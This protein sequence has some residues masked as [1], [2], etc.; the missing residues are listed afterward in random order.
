MDECGCPGPTGLA[1]CAQPVVIGRGIPSDHLLFRTS[2]LWNESSAS[3]AFPYIV[4]AAAS[5]IPSLRDGIL[6][7]ISSTRR[8]LALPADRQARGIF[9]WPPSPTTGPP[10]LFFGGDRVAAIRRGLFGIFSDTRQTSFALQSSGEFTA[11]TDIERFLFDFGVR[12][13]VSSFSSTLRELSSHFSL[14]FLSHFVFCRNCLPRFMAVPDGR[15]L[16]LSESNGIYLWGWS[17]FE[18]GSSERVFGSKGDIV[19]RKLFLP[20]AAVFFVFLYLLCLSQWKC[21]FLNANLTGP[22]NDRLQNSFGIVH[23]CFFCSSN[24]M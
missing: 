16:H 15:V 1:T 13:L 4:A 14:P 12:C 21:T 2:I 17:L 9:S 18:E 10:T 24:F 3:A 20:K 7:A 19:R 6:I 8:R 11:A 5:V 23:C 22:S